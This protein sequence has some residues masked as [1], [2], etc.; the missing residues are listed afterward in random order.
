MALPRLTASL[1]KYGSVLA[2]SQSAKTKESCQNINW[3]YS[4][5]E[6]S[7]QNSLVSEYFNNKK[8]TG[9]IKKQVN[10]DHSK[11]KDK[12]TETTPEEAQPSDF[13]DRH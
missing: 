10:I 3:T 12:L 9:I 2:Q 1:T 4:A 5:E 6:T 13:L 11:E 8:I 7:L